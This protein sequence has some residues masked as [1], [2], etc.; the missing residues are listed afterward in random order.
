MNHEIIITKEY[1]RAN[2]DHVFV[3]GDNLLRK[4]KG[5]AARL[6][7][8][9]NT[10][11]FITKR[12]PNNTDSSFYEISHYVDIFNDEL[13]KLMKEILDNP[14]K[15]YLISRIGAR[16]ANKYGIYELLIEPNIRHYLQYRNVIF[17]WSN[18]LN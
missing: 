8:E 5:G 9:P 10:Y 2:P 1:L 12:V 11:G 17:L 18:Y 15:T 3:F 14:D 4:G 13:L 7:D 6:R 16:L